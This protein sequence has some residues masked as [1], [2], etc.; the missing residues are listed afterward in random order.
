[1]KEKKATVM[2]KVRPDML[3]PPHVVD[4]LI[5]LVN[6]EEQ[7]EST[8]LKTI[9][10]HLAECSYCRTEFIVLLS[11]EQE[12]EKLN[13]PTETI[14]R[15]LFTRVADI[16]QE[17]DALNYE[18]MGAYAE[19]ILIQGQEEAD[20]RFPVLTKHIERCSDCKSTLEQTLEF[21]KRM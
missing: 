13:T 3:V 9:A 20:K 6:S 7:L 2:D 16:H 8:Q 19:A 17:I 1:M 12:Y 11:A 14:M 10:A 4:T 21:L 15:D 18:H 5:H